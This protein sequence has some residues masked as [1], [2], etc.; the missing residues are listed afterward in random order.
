ML[1]IIIDYKRL[2]GKLHKQPPSDRINSTKIPI[3]LQKG[4]YIRPFLHRI[5][6]FHQPRVILQPLSPLLRQPLI[7]ADLIQHHIRIRDVLPN[8]VRPRLRQLMRLQMRLQRLQDRPSKRP[9][10]LGIRLLLVVVEEGLD[11]KSAP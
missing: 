6:Q 2:I 8:N 9:L 7:V 5:H 11:E 1:S 4:L 10:M 3:A